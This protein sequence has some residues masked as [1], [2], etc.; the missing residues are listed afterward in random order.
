MASKKAPPDQDWLKMAL[1]GVKPLANRPQ[2]VPPSRP[3]PA[4]L[5]RIAPKSTPSPNVSSGATHEFTVE[6]D[7]E[8]VVGFQNG[9]D[10][11][12]ARRL[13]EGGLRPSVRLDLHGKT[14]AQAEQALDHLFQEAEKRSARCLLIVCGR[15]LHSGERGPVLRDATIEALSL[16]YA[17]LVLAFASAPIELGGRG[18]ILV[19]LKRWP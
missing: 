4:E 3:S 6:D 2:R 5:R 15:G 1:G 10:R 12:H 9:G 8:T 18:A 7:G 17:H 16:R 14:R 11:Q 13:K 19:W